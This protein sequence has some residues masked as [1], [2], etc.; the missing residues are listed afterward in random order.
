MNSTVASS[1]V[2]VLRSHCV[3]PVP[4]VSIRA[5]SFASP[6]T[7]S[8]SFFVSCKHEYWPSGLWLRAYRLFAP[9]RHISVQ[10]YPQAHCGT[11]RRSCF[12]PSGS[13]NM[14]KLFSLLSIQLGQRNT[15]IPEE[16]GAVIWM[17]SN[18]AQL[19]LFKGWF[20]AGRHQL[21]KD[22][23]LGLAT[24]T[25]PCV[26]VLEASPILV[27]LDMAQTVKETC[28]QCKLALAGVLSGKVWLCSLHRMPDLP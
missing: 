8:I 25:C 19:I 2:T 5:T 6:L 1:V 20:A 23:N 7:F 12:F 14:W 24:S 15:F 4:D 17:Y 26:L 11:R 28:I 18:L 3:C 22:H 10:T 21:Q 27:S 13:I 9:L 16:W